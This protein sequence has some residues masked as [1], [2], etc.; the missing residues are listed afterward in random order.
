MSGRNVDLSDGR[1]FADGFPHAAFGWLRDNDPVHWHAPTPHTPDGEGFWVVS[2]YEEVMQVLRDAP[3]FSSET[4]GGRTGGGTSLKDERAVGKI[5]N[6]TDDPRHRL[7]RGLV[8]KGFDGRA[9]A[10]LEPELRR[11]ATGLI[12]GFP[13]DAPFDF[14][15]AFAQELPLQAICLIL[16]VPQDDRA[17][18]CE[19][20]NAGIAAP[21]ANIIAPEYLGRVADY[22][23]GLIADRRNRPSDDVFSRIIHA[24]LDDEDGARLSDEEL[25]NFFLLLFPAGAETTR[26]A[27]AGGLD[28]LMAHPDQMRRLRDDPALMRPAIEEIVRV[29]T[30]SVY[31]RRTVTRDCE[32]AGTPLKRGDKVTI[33]EMSANHDERVFPDPFAFRID[34]QPNRHVGFG[35]G[36]H[37]CLGAGLARLEIRIGLEELLARIAKFESAGANSHL[38]NNRL[39]GLHRQ[40]IRISRSR[41]EDPA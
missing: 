11:R 23:R 21:S 32:L 26:S 33:W 2:R 12:D 3:T 14:V 15:A 36:P 4:G 38:P 5:L 17:M 7:L 30:P 25:V 24:R 40:P 18:L 22:A 39:V 10:A 16:G 31:K 41:E 20:M 9:I 29:T 1:S 6:Y 37:I 35:F 8:N 34:R 19:W 28:L 27:L 13:E